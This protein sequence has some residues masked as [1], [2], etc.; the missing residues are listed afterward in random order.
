MSGGQQSEQRGRSEEA[1]QRRAARELLDVARG[2]PLS[3]VLP[4][5]VARLVH[6]HCAAIR[7]GIHDEHEELTSHW[8]RV[9]GRRIPDVWNCGMTLDL[10]GDDAYIYIGNYRRP[11]DAIVHDDKFI[12]GAIVPIS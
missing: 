10:G 1:S 9:L 3:R 5:E 8:A 12:V 11:H 4:S 7:G 6:L 2:M